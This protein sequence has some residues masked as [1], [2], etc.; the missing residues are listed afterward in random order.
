[1]GHEKISVLGSHYSCVERA[2]VHRGLL[3]AALEKTRGY[4]CVSNVHTTMMGLFDSSYRAVTNG[5]LFAVPDG[6]PLVW[7]MRSLGASSQDRVRGP[8]LMRDLVNIGREHKIRHYLYGGSPAALEKLRAYLL[9]EYP[10]AQIVG[11]E[12]PPFRPLEAISAA[13]WQQTADRINLSGAQLVWVGLGAP[14]QELWMWNQ[15]D[16]VNGVMLGVGAAFDLLS[17]VIPEA[18]AALQAVG[19]EW[20]YRL[21]REPGRLWRRY[22]FNNPAFLVLWMVQVMFRFVGKDFR[23]EQ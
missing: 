23:R 13:E 16:R 11:A 4:V 8:S 10:G 6:L 19:M 17:G 5:A 12:S 21:F 18:P 9:K 15:R 2:A 3:N 20:A 14:K 22:I 1:M 7:A